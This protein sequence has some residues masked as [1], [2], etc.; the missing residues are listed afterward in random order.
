MKFSEVLGHE[1][2]KEKISNLIGEGKLP[3]A[4]LLL[5]PEGCGTLPVALAIAQSL[6]CEKR[7]GKSEPSLFGTPAM[8]AEPEVAKAPLND[9]CGECG[10]CHKA[11]KFIH[12]DIH[13][14]FPTIRIDKK[15]DPVSKDWL[16]EWRTALSDNPYMGYTQWLPYLSAENKQGNLTVEECHNIIQQLNLKTFEAN[17]KVQIIWMAEFMGTYGNTLLK[18]LEE[19]PENTV[20]ILIVEN[21]ELLL[22]TILSRTQIIKF[23]ALEDEVLGNFLQTKFEMDTETARRIARIS[24]GNVNAALDYA[25]GSEQPA[26]RQ[27]QEWLSCCL[28]LS[29]PS[30]Q[31]DASEKLSAWIEQMAK[32]GREN[33]KIFLKYFLWFLRE[34]NQIRLGL[35]SEKLEGQELEFAKKL[36][37]VLNQDG[38][39]KMQRLIS[40]LHYHIERNG[41]PKI[42]FMANSFALS[43]AMKTK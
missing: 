17:F 13:F 21:Q 26:E 37:G 32:S 22:N 43:K 20:I 18:T 23:G 2:T 27:L 9:A 33:Q 15:K 34:A 3:H 14:S 31:A 5:G 24:D 40:E 16:K 30:H 4:L 6:V 11:A 42:L 41:N 25:N 8:F 39:E 35:A 12:P 19:P 7:N 36:S 29:L 1:A 10:A 28:R 38:V